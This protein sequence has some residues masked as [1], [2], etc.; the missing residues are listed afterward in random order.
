LRRLIVFCVLALAGCGAEESAAPAPTVDMSRYG[1]RHAVARATPEAPKVRLKG[2]SPA[3]EIGV[4]DVT[5][6]VAVR[7]KA[8][9]TSSD[10]SLERLTWSSWDRSGAAGRGEFEVQDCQPNCATG[11][12]RTVAA[13]VRL[14]DVQDCDGRRYFGKAEVTLA[15]G[16]P[17]ATYV[18]A[19]C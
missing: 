18:R 8:L 5:G 6:A 13:T 19:P 4:V 2:T 11:H 14:S 10:A 1:P 7:P 12:T 9:E 15:E 3:G 16:A 17:P